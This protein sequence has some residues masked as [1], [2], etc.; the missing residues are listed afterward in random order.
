MKAESKSCLLASDY[1]PETQK[2]WKSYYEKYENSPKLSTTKLIH[3]TQ[4]L[5]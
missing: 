2:N 5:S 3:T 1:T 4:M